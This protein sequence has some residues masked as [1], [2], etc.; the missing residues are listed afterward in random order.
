GARPGPATWGGSADCGSAPES[1]YSHPRTAP[2]RDA[3]GSGTSPRCRALCRPTADRWTVVT[4][5]CDGDATRTPAR[6][7]LPWID[8]VRS[9]LPTRDCSNALLPWGPLPR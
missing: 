8:S 5:R 9:S 4:F 2:S 3:A 1:D 6:Y 7:G